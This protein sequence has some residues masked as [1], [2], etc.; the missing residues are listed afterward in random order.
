MRQMVDQMY[1]AVQALDPDDAYVM[2]FWQSVCEERGWYTPDK[3]NSLSRRSWLRNLPFSR[4]FAQIGPRASTSRWMSAVMALRCHY[5][6]KTERLF[7]IGLICCFSGWD[8]PSLGVYN[9]LPEKFKRMHVALHRKSDGQP[10]AEGSSSASSSSAAPPVLPKSAAAVKKE[11]AEEKAKT[12][13]SCKNTL[14]VAGTYLADYDLTK[15]A[16]MIMVFGTPIQKEQG[17][18]KKVHVSPQGSM[19][20]FLDCSKG[21]RWLDTCRQIVALLGNLGELAKCGLQC[22][23]ICAVRASPPEEH[24]MLA[25]DCLAAEAFD[26][27]SWLL[28]ERCLS[29]KRHEDSYP[30]C[31]SRALGGPVDLQTCLDRLKIDWEAYSANKRSALPER[32]AAARASS[33]DTRPMQDFA[34]LARAANYKADQATPFRQR[35]QQ[36]FECWGQ[37]NVV[38]CC[39][40][41]LRDHET[42]DAPGKDMS[43]WK[44]FDILIQSGIVSRFGATEASRT[45]Q[46]PVPDGMQDLRRKDQWLFGLEHM[47]WRRQSQY[48]RCSNEV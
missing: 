34:R 43:M 45:N 18:W 21:G 47:G 38:E 39:M 37:E 5:P 4:L 6:H 2:F 9:A 30:F 41:K 24:V 20:Y 19:K 42:R 14:H 23:D 28:T 25:Q 11:V 35:V 27:V 16:D 48:N 1:D 44:Q 36:V 10:V 3:T 22:N 29:M 7:M 15:S 8:L 46:L 12:Y 33:L 17:Y 26:M 40:Q 13:K 31:L 32:L